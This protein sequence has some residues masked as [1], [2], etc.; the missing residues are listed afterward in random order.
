MAAASGGL[1]REGVRIPAGAVELVGDLTIPQGVRAI[2]LF[3]H[4]SGSSRRSP[5]NQFV[6]RQLSLAGLATLLFDLLTPAEEERD[7]RTGE[8]RFDVLLLAPR[9]PPPPPP[10]RPPPLTR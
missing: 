2:V 4:G 8:L 10:L 6:A 7:R 3:A 5:R 1:K 9:L